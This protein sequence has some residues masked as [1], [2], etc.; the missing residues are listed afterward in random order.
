VQRPG[1]HNLLC[2]SATIAAVLADTS[3]AL[4]AAHGGAPHTTSGTEEKLA[5]AV[6]ATETGELRNFG[7][8]CLDHTGALREAFEGAPGIA[9]ILRGAAANAIDRADASVSV[10]EGWRGE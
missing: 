4:P 2:S 5:V 8:R 6:C 1:L 3:K 10:F 9:D 7:D